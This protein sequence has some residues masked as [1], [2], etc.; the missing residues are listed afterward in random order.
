MV[1]R[2]LSW[3]S[4]GAALL[5]IAA[6]V[7]CAFEK[8]DAVVTPH[9]VVQKRAEGKKAPVSVNVA[10]ER[11]G[12]FV[13]RRMTGNA[14]IGAEIKLEEVSPVVDERARYGLM[15]N[16]FVPV[17]ASDPAD[18]A[19]RIEIRSI[20]MENTRTFFA[21]Y[22]NPSAAFKAVARNRTESFEKLYRAEVPRRA[23]NFNT[24]S[25]NNR[26]LSMIVGKVLDEM[27]NDPELMNFLAR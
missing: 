14:M 3:A 24:D 26:L 27:L 20:E 16:D 19:L 13:G 17:A 21:N 12:T 1:I 23:V 18:R 15:I 9:V 22:Y 4:R 11:T 2:W 8:Q 7:G 6:I 25:T 10:D 5:L